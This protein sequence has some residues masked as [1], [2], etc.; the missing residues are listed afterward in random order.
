MTDNRLGGGNTD[1]CGRTRSPGG[2]WR[3]SSFSMSNGDCV[4][5]AHLASDRVGIRDS[6]SPAGPHLRFA[7]DVWTSFTGEIQKFTLQVNNHFVSAAC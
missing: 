3:K 2:D 1:D 7:P 5:V 4:E 6:K